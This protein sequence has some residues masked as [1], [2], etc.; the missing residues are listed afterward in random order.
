VTNR[1]LVAFVTGLV[2]AGSVL[3]T[4]CSTSNS[5][6][7][8]STPSPASTVPFETPTP[9]ATPTPTATGTSTATPSTSDSPSPTP[10]PTPSRTPTPSPTPSTL[11]KPVNTYAL[12]R[13]LGTKGKGVF[14]ITYDPVVVCTKAAVKAAEA[15]K[16]CKPKPAKTSADGSWMA[17]TTTMS[18]IATLSPTVS[19]TVY[20][21]GVS[22]D[23]TSKNLAK[24]TAHN[25]RIFDWST[26]TVPALLTV[27]KDEIK[28]VAGSKPAS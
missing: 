21:A 27:A 10:T 1:G 7:V 25:G 4:G 2:V 16:Q 19:G 11:T 13:G 8:T 28:T 5:A 12:V 6:T 24:Q 23:V 3:A 17:R 20:P 22:F 14:T 9:S 18:V 15:P 26:V